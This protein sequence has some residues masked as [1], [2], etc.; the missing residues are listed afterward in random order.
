MKVAEEDS[1]EVLVVAVVA[2]PV[3]RAMVSITVGSVDAVIVSV[4]DSVEVM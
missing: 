2:D 3:E 4:M 1:V